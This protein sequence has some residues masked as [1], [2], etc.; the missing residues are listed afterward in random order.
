LLKM[1]T[2]I[3]FGT[4]QQNQSNY[5]FNWLPSVDDNSL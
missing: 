4:L 1:S 3:I 5:A 2:R